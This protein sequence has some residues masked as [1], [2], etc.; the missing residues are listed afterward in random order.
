MVSIPIWP[1][2]C[3]GLD[4]PALPLPLL[5]SATIQVPVNL[6]AKDL[7]DTPWRAQAHGAAPV[8]QSNG[9]PWGGKLEAVPGVQT[10]TLGRHLPTGPAPNN[11]AAP[12]L[13]SSRQVHPSPCGARWASK[14]GS[15]QLG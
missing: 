15:V 7:H 2:S 14:R 13:P 3:T 12:P 4:L 8:T 5:L 1:A 10:L 6:R 9:R 11:G